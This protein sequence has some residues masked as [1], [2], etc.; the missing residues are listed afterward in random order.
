MLILQLL[1]YSWRFLTY[2]D[3]IFITSIVFP[4]LRK[5]LHGNTHR[6]FYIPSVCNFHFCFYL[7]SQSIYFDIL[8][9]DEGWE[10]FI[11]SPTRWRN[12]SLCIVYTQNLNIFPPGFAH[13]LTLNETLL[14][15]LLLLLQSI[16][17]SE[18]NY[19]RGFSGKAF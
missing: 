4:L 15:V 14:N 10:N 18:L 13:K 1:I 5:N 8:V 7:L 12:D 2:K 3:T 6:F 19:S 9:Y 16:V 11:H 17:Y